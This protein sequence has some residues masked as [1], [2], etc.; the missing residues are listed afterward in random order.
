MPD[1]EELKNE[2]KELN[3]GGMAILPVLHVPQPL[4][5]LYSINV[6]YYID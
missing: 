1:Y 5:I 4:S 6:M 3:Q 2:V